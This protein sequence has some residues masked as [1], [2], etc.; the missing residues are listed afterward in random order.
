[1]PK[2]N[3][4]APPVALLDLLGSEDSL[5][6]QLEKEIPGLKAQNRGHDFS[7]EGEQG[8]IELVHRVVF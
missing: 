5:I 8:A 4:E 7:L 6:R 1:M 3:F 2:L